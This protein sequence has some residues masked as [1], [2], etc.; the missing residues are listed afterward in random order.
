[1]RSKEEAQDYRY[2][3]DPDLLPL[4]INSELLESARQS[5]PELPDAKRQ[6]F[7]AEYALS[8]MEASILTEEEALA[9]FFEET[10]RLSSEPK[11]SANWILR[12]LLEKMK[13]ASGS[14]RQSPV[15]PSHIAELIRLVRDNK[16]SSTQAKEVFQEMWATGK[17][18]ELIV[19]EKG[20]AQL[21]DLDTVN[22]FIDQVFTEN[23]DL[24]ARFRNGETKLQGVLV[25]LVLKKS[26]GKANPAVVN[27]LLKERIG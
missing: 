6:R 19:S 12:D 16:I 8:K 22:H 7:Q 13:E 9:E 11:Q 21:S 23:S 26:A 14:I 1:M 4:T 20:L 5:L 25:G 10:V 2:F 24:A 18:P 17:M 3:P 15:S 27:K